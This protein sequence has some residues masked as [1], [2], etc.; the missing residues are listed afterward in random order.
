MASPEFAIAK[1][2]FSA[3]LLRKDPVLPTS[4]TREDVDTFHT[5]FQDAVRQCSPQNVQV[6]HIYSP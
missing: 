1:A 3:A 5:L 6:W 2:A 4:C